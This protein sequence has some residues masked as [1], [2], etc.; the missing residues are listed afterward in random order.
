MTVS[1]K[2]IADRLGAEHLGPE[3]YLSNI[4]ALDTASEHDLSFCDRS[5]ASLLLNSGAGA[6]ICPTGCPD[7]KGCTQIRT[8]SPRYDFAL[9]ATECFVETGNDPPIHPTAIVH[10]DASVG[11]GCR[12]GPYVQ[13]GEAV[14]LGDHCVIHG[15]TI[16]GGTGFGIARDATG[17]LLRLPH[18]GRVEVE[19][20][21][22]IGP[23]CTI[24]RAMFKVTR[25]GSGTKLSALIHVAH[26][27]TIGSNTIVAFGAGFSGGATVGADVTIHPKVAIGTDVTVGRG[28]IVGMNSTVLDDVPPDTT[29]VGSPARPV[30]QAVE[31]SNHGR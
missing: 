16:I 17:S 31:V 2:N 6:I 12:I 30:E 29:V 20:N 18:V 4:D 21:V 3:V 15:G 26:H 27:V 13:I 5:D 7:V 1:S 24:D 14:S 28:A 8:L 19:D 22:E 11:E 9:I 10:P 25:I 23:N